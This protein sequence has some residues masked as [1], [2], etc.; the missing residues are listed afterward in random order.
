[1]C[2][3][4]WV[5]TVHV[6]VHVRECSSHSVEYKGGQKLGKVSTSWQRECVRWQRLEWTSGQVWTIQGVSFPRPQGS[7]HGAATHFG[8]PWEGHTRDPCRCSWTWAEGGE[9]S[10]VMWW[11][12]WGRVWS[13]CH[14]D[15]TS[16]GTTMAA[17]GVGRQG[18]AGGQ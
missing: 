17:H 6:T 2:P 14:E 4:V 11:G 7:P 8:G 10:G 13:P 18:R 1:M 5:V 9:D 16:V 3:Q 15:S 12:A